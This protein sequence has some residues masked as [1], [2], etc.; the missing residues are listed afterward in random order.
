MPLEDNPRRLASRLGA[1]NRVLARRRRRPG[2]GR[3]A[4]PGQ[5]GPSPGNADDDPAVPLGVW[6]GRPRNGAF[7][8]RIPSLLK[9]AAAAGAAFLA[10][11]APAIQS[12]RDESIPVPQG[13][14]WAWAKDEPGGRVEPAGREDSAPRAPRAARRVPDDPTSARAIPRQRFQRALEA[15][16]V[17]KGFPKAPDRSQA[18]FLLSLAI[19]GPG[20]PGPGRVMTGV[21][22]GVYR[23]GWYR[24]WGGPWPWGA[25]L[26]QPWGFGW[27]GVPYWGMEGYPVYPVAPRGANVVALLRQ[28][29]SGEVAWRAQYRADAYDLA[30][31][32]QRHAQR[33]AERLVASLR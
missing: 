15:A 9:L 3:P 4:P 13:A 23:G 32:T 11:C 5:A 27:Y 10:A 19:E 29:S 20:R 22:I 30:Y 7:E 16:L 17:A 14:T 24:P 6:A 28:R 1:Q 12:Q 21:R 31:L 26:W 18:D 33:I 8:M 2:R 25:W